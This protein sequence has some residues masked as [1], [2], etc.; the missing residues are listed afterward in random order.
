MKI[1]NEVTAREFVNCGLVI[2]AD[3]G[4]P[5]FQVSL[6]GNGSLAIRSGEV[7]AHDGRFMHD[8]LSVNPVAPNKI[9]LFRNDYPKDG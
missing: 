2:L 4:R 9:V 1:Y 7:C 5:L 8:T 6:T 3:D